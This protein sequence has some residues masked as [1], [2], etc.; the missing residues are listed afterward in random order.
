[1]KK[2][3]LVSIVLV[4]YNAQDYIIEALESIWRQTYENIELIITDDCS[5]DDTLCICRKWL[6]KHRERFVD[7]QILCATSNTG[8]GANRNRGCFA[9]KG[10]WIKQIDDDDRLKP[11]CISDYVEYI[12]DNPGK[13]IVFSPLE[14]F[15]T[16][17]LEKWKIL[18][19]TNFQYI[20]NLSDFKRKVLLCKNC[21]FP[22]PSAFINRFFF[23]T[24]GG[25][26]ENIKYLDDWEFWLRAAF[27]NAKFAY[28]DKTEVE[29]RI[30]PTSVSQGVG[31]TNKLYLESIKLSEKSILKYMRRISY[32]YYIDGVIAY[33]LKYRKSK[34]WKALFYLRVLNPYFW[35]AFIIIRTY[36]IKKHRNEKSCKFV[37]KVFYPIFS[38]NSFIKENDSD[39]C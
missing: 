29:Y 19:Q 34:F 18:L 9:A 25:Y 35:F 33:N 14:P 36:N 15:G 21:L 8:I 30:S 7:S 12:L 17:D 11:S 5:V 13:S 3:P 31:G 2:K 28:I 20:L 22:A 39:K 32:L 24:I 37:N 1:M 27:N 4:T 6:Q 10:E 23:I 26:N 38:T 16:V